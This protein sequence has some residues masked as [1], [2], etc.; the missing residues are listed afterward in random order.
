M[1]VFTDLISVSELQ[2]L[3]AS[4][5]A[6]AGAILVDCR[7]NLMDIGQGRREYL[8]GHIPGAVYAHLDDD[9][10]S[11]IT[12]ES[13]RH[14]LPD[15]DDFVRTLGDWG[16]DHDT[17]VVVY[18]HSNGA[19][20][21]RLWW[22]LRWLGHD[23]VA[24]LDGGFAAWTSAK[25]GLETEVA[26][27]RSTTFVATPNFD[28]VATTAEIAEAVAAGDSLN[29]ID[30]RDA[31]RFNGEMEP[32]DAVAGHVPGAL[33]KPFLGG[34]HDDGT[35][36]DP[37]EHRRSWDELLAGRPEKPLIAMC[38]SGVTACH[39]LISARLSGLPEPRLYVG[40]WSEWI[41]VAGRPVA[42]AK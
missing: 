31:S 35:W 29:I 17:Q 42:T 15:V 23:N 32:I 16:I 7:F 34:V 27:H 21:A 11:P 38:G 40:S 5:S 37:G 28:M 22:L 6:S 24:V 36:L 41:R 14:P 8:A 12:V 39:L 2:A 4:A 18:D 9:L 13:G 20:A 25:G 3:S 1:T 33:N 10:A 19:V 26:N 30:A